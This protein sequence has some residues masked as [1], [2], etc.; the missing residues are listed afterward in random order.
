[1][2]VWEHISGICLPITNFGLNVHK[3]VASVSN[4]PTRPV[5]YALA[6]NT[7]L[8]DKLEIRI[9]VMSGDVL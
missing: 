4:S 7:E 6:A 1:M 8:F 2:L 9:A 5:V 3:L